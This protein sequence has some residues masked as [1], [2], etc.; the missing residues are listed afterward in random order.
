VGAEVVQGAKDSM[1][2]QAAQ[3]VVKPPESPSEQILHAVGGEP[4]LQAWRVAK[5]VVTSADSL[6]R[7]AAA[8]YPQAIQDFH[9]T[10]QDFH[11]GDYRNAASSAVSAA[12][13]AAG[14]I[15][16]TLVP[17]AQS[18]RELSEGARPGGNLATPLTRQA[19]DAVTML[20]AGKVGD[21]LNNPQPAANPARVNPFRAAANKL[22]GADI[23]PTL[24]A[25]I[26][27]VWNNVADAEN[28]PKPKPG[29][30]VG[31]AGQQVGDAI[32]ARSK[33]A[34]RQIDDATGGRFSGLEN[35]LRN[36]NRDLRFVTNDTEE[37]NLLIRKTR[38]EMQLG[39]EFDEAA[40]KGVTKDT[41]AQ[42]KADF[43]KA[44][45]I[46]DTNAQIQMSTKGVRPGMAGSKDVPETVDPKG[47]M[48]RMNKLY[49]KGRLQDGIGED[50]SADLI[51]HSAKAQSSAAK[52]AR[53]QKI[54]GA[55][56]AGT[57][58]KHVVPLLP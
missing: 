45:S 13:D 16:P 14:I 19:I 21:A 57:A 32:L 11:N 34:Y 8:E 42:A 15:N 27:D 40:K 54:A 52:V 6:M 37:Q 4:A 3:S 18:T 33:A 49:N 28:V 55:V 47:L 56:A 31:D 17:L 43:K 51:S 58:L 26:Q 10:I 44:Q 35:D 12:T 46:F 29:L 41:V 53:N 23:Q 50:N 39:Q 22:T 48:N 7:A 20:A 2:G 25:G 30:S 1:I 5:S 36:V 24:K 9:R 38:L